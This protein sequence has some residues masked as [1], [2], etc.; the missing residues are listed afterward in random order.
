MTTERAPEKSLEQSDASVA[1]NARRR[2]EDCRRF[3]AEIAR[4]EFKA[5]WSYGTPSWA[6]QA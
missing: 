4:A 3:A 6:R 2:E 5:F 1:L